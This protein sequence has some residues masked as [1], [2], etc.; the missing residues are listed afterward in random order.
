MSRL[1]ELERLLLDAARRIESQAV[2]VRPT[3]QDRG[4]RRLWKRRSTPLLAGLA[5]LVIA[6]AA[7]AAATALLDTGEPVPRAASSSPP[8]PANGTR[9]FT[10]ASVRAADLD[11]GPQW[12]IGTYESAPTPRT[13]GDAAA[14]P[15]TTMTCVVVG[16]IQ[17]G[18]LG[19]IGRD[20]VFR[21]DGRFH[22]LAPTAQS[23]SVCGGRSND[24]TFI[25]HSSMPPIPASGYTGPLGTVIG[26]CRERVNLEGPTVSPQ[27]RRKLR[28]VPE[29]SA[30]SLR[31]VI[32]GF[33]GPGGAS[34]TLA[35][36]GHRDTLKLQPKENGAYLFVVRG[37]A[38]DT[39]RLTIAD[40][41]GKVCT[42]S[43]RSACLAP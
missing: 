36:P 11:G 17:N 15:H 39:Y 40:R 31:R 6:S 12:G 14:K 7:V 24:G 5:S 18:R 43:A 29:C 25:S 8:A 1:P 21:N 13:P 26:G 23:S 30:A 28:G 4:R 19:V 2:V 34:A 37:D 33:A 41:S 9:G 22:E 27:T 3:I 10:L 42:L 38:P 35:G 16:R 32:A 20:G